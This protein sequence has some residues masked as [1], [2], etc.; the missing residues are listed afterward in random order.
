ML[1][2]HLDCSSKKPTSQQ[3]TS[4]YPKTNNIIIATA[5]MT[6]TI[7]YSHTDE[8]KQIIHDT[9]WWT[10]A[11]II[12]ITFESDEE[13][14]HTNSDDGIENYP[15]ISDSI[16]PEAEE[17]KR[18]NSL[19]EEESDTTGMAYAMHSNGRTRLMPEMLN[20]IST[21]PTLILTTIAQISFHKQSMSRMCLIE[22]Q[23]QQIQKM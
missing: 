18:V 14:L 20:P 15:I 5:S 4:Q 23:F 22:R 1:S 2:S 16:P 3:M 13:D 11:H 19:A 12:T 8:N 9:C 10:D 17:E 6:T 7:E 21:P